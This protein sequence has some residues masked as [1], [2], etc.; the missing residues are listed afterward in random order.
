VP[1]KKITSPVIIPPTP[2]APFRQN[3]PFASTQRENTMAE[4][5][6]K[7]VVPNVTFVGGSENIVPGGSSSGKGVMAEDV[8]NASK[9]KKRVD[10]LLH[11]DPLQEQA[12]NHISS[13]MTAFVHRSGVVKEVRTP[14][15]P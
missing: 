1:L 9:W 2:D 4:A 3:I 10:A 11:L 15:R 5:S 6:A 12:S 8:G 7:D 13:T 14:C